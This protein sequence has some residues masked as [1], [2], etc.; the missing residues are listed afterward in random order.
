MSRTKTVYRCTACGTEAPKWTGW[1][2]ACDASG[3]LVAEEVA[4]TRA[5]A[6]GLAP[7]P[8]P[9]V[10]IAEA[11]ANRVEPVSTT[12]TEVDRVLGGGLV[13]GAVALL[14]GEPGIGKSTLLLQVGAAMASADH[15][16]LYVTAEESAPQV[17]ARAGRL[18][19]LDPGLWLAAE[20][21]LPNVLRLLDD[22]RPKL[23]VVDSIQALVDPT[24]GSTAGSLAQ[25]RG[26]AQ[27]LVAA[28]KRR[29]LTVVVVGHV[30]KEGGLAGPKVLEHVVD[31]VLSFEGERH[32]AL[33]LLRAVKHRFGGTH[34][35]GLFEMG[36]SGLTGVPDPSALFL[37]DRQP[38]IPGTVVAPVLDGDRPLLVEVQALVVPTQATFPRRTAQGVDSGRLSQVLAVL[39]R[40]IGLPLS[41]AEVHVA[42]AGGVR[43][44]EPGADVAVALAVASS[45]GE[46]PVAPGLVACGEVGLGGELRQVHRTD[47]RLSEAARLGFATALVPRSAPEPPDGLR[48][49]RVRSLRAALDAALSTHVAGQGTCRAA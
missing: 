17:A 27:A 29:G 34:E 18:G 31:T 5:T 25:V 39:E 4:A 33:R 9:A 2:G 14:G 26:C 44:R 43:V 46:C 48:T 21:S 35:L 45:L 40:R 42:V 11:V 24:L 38:G 19:A 36:D 7:P 41:R 10:P 6:K 20:T 37:A 16:T 15:R 32:H 13:P 28:A 49:V 1:C 30:T 12:V 22:V 8:S 23:L 3:T 47:R